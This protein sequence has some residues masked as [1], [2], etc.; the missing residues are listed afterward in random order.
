MSRIDS[1]LMKAR[2][3]VAGV[4]LASG[5]CSCASQSASVQSQFTEVHA[6]ANAIALRLDDGAVFITDDASNAVLSSTDG[7]TFAP[8]AAVPV[9]AGQPNSLSQLVFA[10]P[11]TLLIGRFG[12]GTSGAIFEIGQRGAATVLDGL[13]PA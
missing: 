9:T 3:I 5:L 12:F 1:T 10:D 6:R 11:Q 7:R 2:W 13:D 4:L 8:Y